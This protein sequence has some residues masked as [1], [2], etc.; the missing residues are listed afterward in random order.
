MVN[1][2][3]MKKY[4]LRSEPVFNRILAGSL[5]AMVAVLGMVVVVAGRA[6]TQ[7]L[8]TD[9]AIVSI[10]QNTDFNVSVRINSGTDP[11]NAVEADLTYDSTKLQ[12]VSVSS[13]GSDFPLEASTQATTGSLKLARAT[14]PGSAPITGD[15]LVAIVTF[16]SLTGSGSSSITF[17]GSSA[18]VRSTDNTNVLIDSGSTTVNFSVP[19]TP[20]PTPSAT[21]TPTSTPAPT[22]SP[23]PTPTPTPNPSGDSAHLYLSPANAP[24]NDNGSFS[25]QVREDSGAAAV[26]AVQANL[27]YPTNLLEVTSVDETGSGFGLNASTSSSN[28]QISIAR[29]TTPGG[30]NVTGNQL[31]ATINFKG[32]GTAGTASVSGAAGSAVVRASDAH[33]I[34]T[35]TDGGS[36]VLSGTAPTPT[37]T[38]TP[39]HTPTPTPVVHTPTPTPSNPTPVVITNNPTPPTVSGTV[40]F[41][42]PTGSAGQD[43]AYQID[44]TP[45]P[46]N[47]VDTTTL[48]DGEHVVTATTGVGND[49]KTTKQEITVSN[50]TTSFQR[51]IA[52]LKT[53]GPV[54]VIGIALL[55][56]IIGGIVLARKL[57]VSSSPANSAIGGH[58]G[59][60]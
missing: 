49:K 4:L 3:A 30:P 25:V 27:S 14:N 43:I 54:L 17:A 56:V 23:T 22:A 57:I 35:K 20:T 42:A 33:D 19:A 24:Y 11:V 60:Y 51:L 21:P 59:D 58:P 8:Y 26:N 32:K 28:G 13:T 37:P 7:Q 50:Q 34:L 40:K 18:V 9:P 12:Y 29:G 5:I 45:L 39:T 10:N 41:V 6:A 44:N 15:G 2:S 48:N 1:I 36:Y 55:A 46:G 52:G 53:N 47:T 16:H 31:I 38:A